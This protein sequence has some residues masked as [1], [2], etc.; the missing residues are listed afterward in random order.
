MGQY[1]SMTQ[2][3]K[4]GIEFDE[5]YCRILSGSRVL[6]GYLEVDEGCRVWFEQ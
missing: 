4:V 1:R 2:T 6:L 5:F 3:G